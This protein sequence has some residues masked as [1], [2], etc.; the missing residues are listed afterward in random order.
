MILLD[1]CEELKAINGY[2]EL[3][4]HDELIISVPEEHSQKG[5][6]LLAK[7]MIAAAQEKVTSFPFYVDTEVMYRWGEQIK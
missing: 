7:H 4:V 5:E 2:I 6:E 3:S 1:E